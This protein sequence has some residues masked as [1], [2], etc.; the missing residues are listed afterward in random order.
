MT[1]NPLSERMEV[2]K[3]LTDTF[4]PERIV[5]I[6]IIILCAITFFICL[7]FSLI[8][9]DI[10]YAESLPMLGSSGTIA[11][12]LGRLMHMFDRSAS[13]LEATVK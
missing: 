5:N 10:G 6:A 13:L 4:K 1:A 9:G 12:L 11:F 2:V 3:Q 7:I 8:R